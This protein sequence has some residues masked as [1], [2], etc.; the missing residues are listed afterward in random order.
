MDFPDQFTWKDKEWHPRKRGFFDTIGRI[1]VFNP[2]TG[3]VYFLRILPHH[4]HCKGKSTFDDLKI[5]NGFSLET[6]Q[7]VCKALGLL[8]DDRE[9]LEEGALTKMPPALRELFV[10]IVLFC[11]PSNPKELIEMPHLEWAEDFSQQANKKGV[12]LTESRM[13]TLVLIDIQ[14]RL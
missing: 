11:M 12:N 8:Q 1:H 7:E 14:K 2:T 10:I 3:D 9:A 6:Y 5:Y 13:R 4:D